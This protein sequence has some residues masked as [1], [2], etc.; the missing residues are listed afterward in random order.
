MRRGCCC[1]TP[2]G[3]PDLTW[4]D[5]TRAA[6]P[7]R[8]VLE[9]AAS[10]L[11]ML[12]AEVSSKPTQNTRASKRHNRLRQTRVPCAQDAD[13][14]EKAIRLGA[15]QAPPPSPLHLLT[16]SCLSLSSP[17]PPFLRKLPDLSPLQVL[18]G[19]LR[20]HPAHAGV[21]VRSL[22]L[23]RLLHT[24]EYLAVHWRS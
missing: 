4:S 11:Q 18:V 5:L 16:P 22:I 20:A 19:S 10:A 1:S 8:Q 2:C 7:S 12:C 9:Q 3:Y 13:I 23:V 24:T 14:R 15:V 6:P 21:Q 17:I